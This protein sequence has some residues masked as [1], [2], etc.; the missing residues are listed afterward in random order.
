MENRKATSWLDR[1]MSI[2]EIHLGSWRRKSEEEN[3]WYSY[4]EIAAPLADYL[5]TM[6]YTH[7]EV[8]PLMEYPYDPSWGYQVTGYFAVTRRY[9]SP[10]DF[11]YF[12]DYMHRHNIG[13]IMDWVPAHF[14]KDD[15][16]LRWFDGTA[17]FEHLDPRLGEHPDWGTLIF[18]YGRNEV[19]NFL[20]AS[21]LFW[22]EEY[23]I[24]GLRVDAVASMLYLDY[25]RNEGQWLPNKYGG[26]ENLEAIAFIKKLNEIVHE[27]FPGAMMIAEEST[28]WPMVSRPTYLGGL[29]FTFKW[30]MGWMTDFLRY[31]K[32]DPIHRKYHQNL[33]TFSMYYAFSENFI[34]PLSHDEVVHGKRSLLD[35]MPGDT[36][37]KMANFRVALG[38]MYGH[39]GKKLTFMGSEFGQW[40]EW[41]HA[42]SLQWHL[43]EQEQ[44]RQLQQYVKDLNALYRHEPALYEI[45][46]SWEGFQWIDFQDF[47]ASIISFIRYGKNTDEALIFACNF[48]PV[49]RPQYRIGVPFLTSYEEILNSDSQHY[50]GSNMGNAGKVFAEEK[51]HHN[52]D[53][54][55]QITFPPLAV[56][57]F[58]GKK[59][60]TA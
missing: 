9:G 20:I 44:H 3:G 56:L 15:W 41:N 49:P 21:A 31:M 34:L 38:Y 5:T 46:Y 33:I 37:Q 40:W 17:L 45:D 13:V 51:P 1:P 16:A 48:T 42:D 8:M 29:G 4:R 24:D 32:E 52:Q 60:T 23:H 12:V 7:I 22:L 30:N 28:A 11:A 53:Y 55:M 47:D 18:N 26:R 43:L 25:S 19:R 57:V 59:Q 6:G 27:K 14:P 50:G 39:P 35:K 54:S 2:Y 36:W 58:K 10:D